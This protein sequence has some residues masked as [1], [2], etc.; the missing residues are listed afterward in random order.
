MDFMKFVFLLFFFSIGVLSTLAYERGTLR[1]G[2]GNI[3]QNL[4]NRFIDFIASKKGY[5]VKGWVNL[6]QLQGSIGMINLRIENN[7]VICNEGN[8]VMEVELVGQKLLQSTKDGIY[9]ELHLQSKNASVNSKFMDKIPFMKT[10][11]FIDNILQYNAKTNGLP[12]DFEGYLVCVKK[13][14]KALLV[15]K[16]IEQVEF[17]SAPWKVRVSIDFYRCPLSN[18]GRIFLITI[19]DQ[20]NVLMNNQKSFIW[21]VP[22]TSFS[23][24]YDFHLG[25]RDSQ[26]GNFCELERVENG[27]DLRLN[28]PSWKQSYKLG[29]ANAVLLSAYLGMS[30]IQGISY[31][32]VENLADEYISG[33]Y[34]SLEKYPQNSRKRIIS[35]SYRREEYEEEE[36]R[37]NLKKVSFI[38]NIALLGVTGLTNA[39][40]SIKSV[41]EIIKNLD[42]FNKEFE[43]AELFYPWALTYPENYIS[44]NML[45]SKRSKSTTDI[46]ESVNGDVNSK[47]SVNTIS[48]NEAESQNGVS[49]GKEDKNI[50]NGSKNLKKVEHIIIKN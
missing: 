14:S 47:D 28:C 8:Q 24:V 44:P 40:Y 32:L 16:S 3:F 37:R 20:V 5:D 29:L 17:I 50:G 35:A 13:N 1:R 34:D 30:F 26:K 41:V 49:Q 19:I 12:S 45:K 43:R 4:K 36:I 27:F 6:S 25:V 10:R 15:P 21:P 2:K 46:T 38:T 7:T 11:S 33:K 31:P 23:Q 39:V 48:Y 18:F 42:N 9:N 22:L